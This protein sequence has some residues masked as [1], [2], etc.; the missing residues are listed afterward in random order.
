M[1]VAFVALLVSLGGISW[2]LTL[3]RNSVGR[4]QLKNNAVGSAEVKNGSLRKR[5]F[6]AGQLPAGA[7]GPAGA[8][9]APGAT[10][11]AGTPGTNATINGVAAGGD[12][13]GTYPS[14]TIA[15]GAVTASKLAAVPAA[16]VKLVAD[17]TINTSTVTV[18][19]F[20]GAG[21]EDPDNGWFDPQNLHDPTTHPERIVA[22]RAGLYYAYLTVNWDTGSAFSSEI[23]LEGNVSGGTQ[24][25]GFDARD[26]AAGS[27]AV[28]NISGIVRMT[29]GD[30]VS[31][32]ARQD[33]GGTLDVTTN[34]TSMGLTWIGP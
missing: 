31:G 33:T 16:R 9:G 19:N 10:G 13:A 34:Y 30:Y 7:R 29:A 8:S 28:I 24:T 25:M 21:S 12:L 32:K 6:R 14:P 20:G 11:A 15:N 26:V 18:I 3:P 17:Q 4:S 5:D 23:T 1:V 22:P 27:N 2:A